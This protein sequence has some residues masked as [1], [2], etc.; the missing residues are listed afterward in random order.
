[1]SNGI[2]QVIPTGV[3]RS[4]EVGKVRTDTPPSTSP[5]NLKGALHQLLYPTPCTV[6]A[7]GRRHQRE[8]PRLHYVH[9]ATK[10][11]MSWRK[12]RHE[13]DMT[14]YG[15]SVRCVRIPRTVVKKAVIR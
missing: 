12:P 3:Q 4:E 5:D 10:Q 2:T 13:G 11:Y 14:S 15:P 1:M 9:Q 8:S 7:D 6:L